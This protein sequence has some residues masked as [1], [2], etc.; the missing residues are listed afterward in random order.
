MS[1][2]QL[3]AGIP[4]WLDALLARYDLAPDQVPAAAILDLAAVAAHS[5][6]R[7]AAPLTAFVAGLVAGMRG[8]EASEVQGRLEELAAAARGWADDDT[9]DAKGDR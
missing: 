9:D 8:G 2:T 3:P 7:P 1:E 4:E 5:V 6:T